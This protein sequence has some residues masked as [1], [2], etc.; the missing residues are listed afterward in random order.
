MKGST[1]LR[2]GEEGWRLAETRLLD[3][4]ERVA[5]AATTGQG[6]AATAAASPPARR[7]SGAARKGDGGETSLH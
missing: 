4:E 3:A 2:M 6:Q 7:R 5:P 1:R